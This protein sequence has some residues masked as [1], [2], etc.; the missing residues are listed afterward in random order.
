M[1]T[2][3]RGG[4]IIV[5]GSA[6]LDL[7][8]GTPR[9]PGPGETVLGTSYHEFAGGKGL[10]Q[11]IAAARHGAAVALV[12]AVGADAA[13]AVLADAA[14]AEGIDITGLRRVE[15]VPTGRAL[16][17]VDEQ[18]EN[19]II[20]VP[21]ANAHVRADIVGR[22]RRPPTVV[23]AQCEV[24]LDVVI[25][26]LAAG[27][28]RGALTV[29]N[30]SPATPLPR[31]LLA[32]IDLL[33]PNQHEVDLI[34]GADDLLA[35]GVGAVVVTRGADGIQVEVGPAWGARR[36]T[37]D[38]PRAFHQPSFPVEPVD[39]TGAG[40]ACCGALVAALATGRSLPA[41]VERAAAAGALATTTAGAVPSLPSR[42]A[43]D[44]L[45]AAATP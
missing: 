22:T 1:A 35:A 40:D 28:S 41:A 42:S 30:P 21:G 10:N 27:R 36:A 29:L 18:A 17:A 12:G 37:D 6:N 3:D 9:I 44:A 8:A 15:G 24:D 4:H 11:A 2:A 5:V 45:L 20:V 25:E 39:T 7:V 13:G 38:V 43:V 34:G 19:S 26:A 31:S 33:I 32:D 14:A 16:I 23:L